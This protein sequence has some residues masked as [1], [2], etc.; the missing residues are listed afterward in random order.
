MPGLIQKGGSI[1]PPEPPLATGLNLELQQ[2]V[3]DS[4][5]KLEGELDCLKRQLN[6]TF[7][8][9]VGSITKS[10]ARYTFIG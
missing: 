10:L 4:V 1:E 2:V 9:K 8:E 7:E 5:S 3:A 6:N